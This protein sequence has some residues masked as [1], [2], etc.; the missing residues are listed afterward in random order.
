[1]TRRDHRNF[2]LRRIA[3]LRASALACS[4]CRVRRNAFDAAAAAEIMLAQGYFPAASRFCV[5]G[6]IKIAREVGARSR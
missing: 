2:I 3:N 5:E 6:E 1:M 4:D